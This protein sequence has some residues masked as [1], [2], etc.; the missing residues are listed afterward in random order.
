MKY[1]KIVLLSIIAISIALQAR[2]TKHDLGI[3]TDYQSTNSYKE[4]SPLFYGTYS[5]NFV[6]RWGYQGYCHHWYDI[7][8]QWSTVSGGVKLFPEEV[9]PGD[10]IFVRKADRFLQRIRPKIKCPFIMVT[11]GE[12][13]DRVHEENLEYLDDDNILAWFS[14]HPCEKSHPKLHHIPLGILQKKELYDDRVNLNEYFAELRHAEKEDLLYMN[15]TG[16]G[17]PP[18]KADRELVHH[19]FIDK[20]Y[21]VKGRKRNFHTYLKDMAKAKFALSPGGTG[22]DTY[23]TWEALLVGTIPIVKTSQ[24]DELYSNLPI[25]IVNEWEEVTEELLERTWEEYTS[26]KFN[27]EKMFLDYWW[28]KIENMREAFLST[29]T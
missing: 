3:L 25:L 1:S 14:I 19:M 28:Q 7:R 5:E 2:P 4:H 11:A 20:D 10:I 27:I 29:K 8:N 13:Y 9:Q 15:F 6:N 17:K 22:P 18:F 23:R 16:G 26:K 12:F 24:L 21:C